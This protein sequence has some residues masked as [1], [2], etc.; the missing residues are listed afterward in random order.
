LSKRTIEGGLLR[1]GPV[2]RSNEFYHLNEF[3]FEALSSADPS[4]SSDIP[5]YPHQVEAS[6]STNDKGW[7]YVTKTT[8]EKFKEARIERRIVGGEV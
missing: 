1:Q 7:A 2:I 4:F 6:S 5:L 3:F 8:Y